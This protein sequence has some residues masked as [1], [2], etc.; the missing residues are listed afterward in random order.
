MGHLQPREALFVS[1]P[2]GQPGPGP[3]LNICPGR[4]A[5]AVQ[6]GGLMVYTHPGGRSKPEGGGGFWRPWSM[7]AR[8]NTWV[9]YTLGDSRNTGKGGQPRRY[10]GTGRVREP[11]GRRQARREM[12]NTRVAALS[13]AGRQVSTS[14]TP[15][16]SRRRVIRCAFPV[17]R[18]PRAPHGGLG[19]R[20]ARARAARARREH[21]APLHAN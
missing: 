13:L 1:K 10:R 6:R 18:N 21:A 2:A 5:C 14:P 16:R 4:A 12:K 17:P 20:R 9:L 3:R 8:D 7:D 19:A 11:R 15:K